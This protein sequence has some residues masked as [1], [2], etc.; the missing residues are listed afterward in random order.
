MLFFLKKLNT[1]TSND[2]L[3]TYVTLLFPII[4]FCK[5]SW[6]STKFNLWE[7]SLL[8]AVSENEANLKL[9][10]KYKQRPKFD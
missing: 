7:F 8:H 10:R 6:F 3:F 4:S 2:Y 5:V 9:S 1:S